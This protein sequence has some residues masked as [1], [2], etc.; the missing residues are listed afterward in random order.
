MKQRGDKTL[1]ITPL[2]WAGTTQSLFEA[3][4]HLPWAMLLDSANAQHQDA[5]FDIIAFNPIATL[6]SRNGKVI[7][8]PKD[9][10]NN[11]LQPIFDNIAQHLQ[12]ETLDPF[13]A[14]KYCQQ[15]LY[16]IKQACQYPFSG[17]AIGAFS[18]DLGRSIEQLPN[19]AIKDIDFN[20]LNIGFYDQ[21]LVYDY[22]QQHW[23]SISYDNVDHSNALF[24]IIQQDPAAKIVSKKSAFCLT[25]AWHNQTLKQ[26][27]LNH[28]QRVQAYLLSGDCYQINLT[29][30][31]EATYQG[32]EWQ[33][34]KQL[35]QAN[36][37]PFS[38]FIRLPHHTV[39]SI[40]PE[41]FIQLAGDNIET[42]PIKGTLP[43]LNDAALDL[44]QADKLQASE[45]DRAE[46][47]MIVDLLRND[48]GKVASPGSVKVPHLFSIES[49]PAVHHLVS[50][51]TAKLAPQ[52]DASDLLKACFPGGSITGAPK[53]RAMQIIEE[54]EP[55]RRSIYCGS[56]GYL[57]QDGT[58]D[59]SITIRTLIT[60]SNRIYCWAGGGVVADSNAEAE[61]QECFDKVSKILPL[62]QKTRGC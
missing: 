25:S 43:R 26:T 17:G 14:L 15:Q 56:I 41:R 29:Q 51:V 16:P 31:F 59:T 46:N 48:I 44:L 49:F 57:S 34:Y 10:T 9:I 37:A 45:K 1:T 18:Y 55:S 28:F 54:L 58:M 27:Y 61:Y 8:E 5:R 42:K 50:T 60:E 19:T 52:Y 6:I 38:T 36:K 39:L 32:D 4:S 11:T 53:I 3:V 20:E 30:R 24:S 7:F 22:Q 35:T 13:A 62:L 12:S 23:C 40:S 47:V 33:A 21:C 2:M